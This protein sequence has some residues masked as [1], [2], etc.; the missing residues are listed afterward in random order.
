MSL[1][2]AQKE[3]Y[4]ANGYLSPV[5][6]FDPVTAA[7]HQREF[8]EMERELGKEKCSQAHRMTG[9]FI[10]DDP[11]GR[12]FVW[13]IVSNPVLLDIVESILGGFHLLNNTTFFCRYGPDADKYVAWH[14]DLTYMRMDPPELVTVW[15]A[16]DDTNEENGCLRVIPSSHRQRE[17]VGHGKSLNGGNILNGNQEVFLDDSASSKAVSLPLKRGE[18]AIFSGFLLHG[19]PPNR[20]P[21]RRCGLSLRF[22]PV[23]SKPGHPMISLGILMRG[24]DPYQYYKQRAIPYREQFWPEGENR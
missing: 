7:G 3:F 21:H 1:S 9:N 14:Q 2:V 20:S 19:S 11:F 22:A 16:I 13:D 24:E 18:V 5:A 15:Y 6:I 17:I 12:P 8:D 23:Y 10:F 4:R